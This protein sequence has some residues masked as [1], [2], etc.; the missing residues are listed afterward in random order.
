MHDLK[1]GKHNSSNLALVSVHEKSSPSYNESTSTVVCVEDDK[2]L[3]AL[4][5]WVLNLL[6]ALGSFLIS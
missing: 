6:I 2:I 1:Y 3:F 4:S 5:H